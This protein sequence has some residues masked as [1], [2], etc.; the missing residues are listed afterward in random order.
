MLDNYL[1]RREKITITAIQILDEK[2][3]QG[4]TTREIAKRQQITE[5]AIYR[6]FK[7]KHEI[8]LSIIEQY[9]IFDELIENTI[10]ENEMDA[11]SAIH[12]YI[13]ALTKYYDSYPE[14]TTLMFSMDVYHY[15]DKLRQQLMTEIVLRGQKDGEL[16]KDIEGVKLAQIVLDILWGTIKRWKSEGCSENLTETAFEKI[17]WI[18]QTNGI[19]G[20]HEKSID[21]G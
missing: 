6:H 9:K 20:V 2:G 1:N 21:R 16:T 4:L 11:R 5:P 17:N 14:I 3:I 13:D 7:S 10:R 18:L 8:I 19:G 15:D 12:Y